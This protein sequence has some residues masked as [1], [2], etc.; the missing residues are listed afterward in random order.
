MSR[1]RKARGGSESY[2]EV[3]GKT[4]GR[5]ITAPPIQ[6]HV[7]AR[8]WGFESPLR[9]QLLTDQRLVPSYLIRPSLRPIFADFSR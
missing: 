7:P 6:G 5:L 1:E 4:E 2:V 8:V 9:H 3:S